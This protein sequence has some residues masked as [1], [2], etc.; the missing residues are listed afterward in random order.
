MV[1]KEEGRWGEGGRKEEGILTHR[2]FCLYEN[3]WKQ[4]KN[5]KLCQVTNKGKQQYHTLTTEG[6]KLIEILTVAA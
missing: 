4:T 2:G 5:R 3:R 1:G 6:C